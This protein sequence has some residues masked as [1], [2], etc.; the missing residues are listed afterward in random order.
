MSAG[1]GRRL[2]PLSERWAK[3]VLPIDGRPVLATMLRELAGAGF[4]RVVVVTGHLAHQVERLVGDGSGFGLEAVFVRQP[5]RDGSADAVLRALEGGAR[6]PALVAAADTLFTP[7]DVG[8]FW[9]AYRASGANGALAGRREPPP[10]PPHRFGIRVRAGLVERVLEDDP[11]ATPLSGAP[12]WALDAELAARLP[13]DQK[14]PYELGVVFQQAIDAGLTV[15][16]VEIG[17][18]RDLTYPLDLVAENFSY[19]RNF[20]D[21]EAAL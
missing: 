10:D 18:T 13:G 6:L 14:A 4:T 11:A 3:P 2:Q 16:G 5:R 20:E 17:P 21:S 1:E 19:L 8:R 9:S 7:G 15:A 12:L